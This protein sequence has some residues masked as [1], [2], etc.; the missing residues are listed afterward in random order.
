[1]ALRFFS[2]FFLF[3]FPRQAPTNSDEDSG[4][5]AHQN[6]SKRRAIA[7]VSGAEWRN[8]QRRNL[9]ATTDAFVNSREA[10]R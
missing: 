1:M 4:A 7:A 3:F 6:S 2:L 5:D 10:E 8:A 9:N